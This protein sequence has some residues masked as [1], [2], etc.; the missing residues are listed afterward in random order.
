MNSKYVNAAIEKVIANWACKTDCWIDMNCKYICLVYSEIYFLFWRPN[1][2]IFEQ[3]IWR[4]WKIKFMHDIFVLYLLLCIMSNSF[5]NLIFLFKLKVIFLI[6]IDL[7]MYIWGNTDV[8]LHLILH[9]KICLIYSG[10]S[11]TIK[12]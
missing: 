6:N 10:C 12:M 1:K 11:I 5:S 2:L 4:G 8:F 7:D 9:V 3:R